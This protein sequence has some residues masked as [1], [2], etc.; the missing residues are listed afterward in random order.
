MP[1]MSPALSA[2]D[3]PDYAEV[4]ER[5]MDYS[6]ILTKL[7]SGAYGE[8]AAAFAADMRLVVSNAVLY[9]PEPDN[10]CNLAAKAN[11]VDFETRYLKEG[12]ATDKGAAAAAA[13]EGA[14]K[15]TTRK[16]ARD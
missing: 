11:L 4:I 10:N 2:D 1:M 13:K 9:S 8:D 14:K 12:L 7:N 5:P 15:Q 16:R 3:V 6:T